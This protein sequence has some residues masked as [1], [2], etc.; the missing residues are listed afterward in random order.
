MH[1][2]FNLSLPTG[3]MKIFFFHPPLFASKLYRAPQSMQLATPNSCKFSSPKWKN[4][5][6]RSSLFKRPRNS[7]RSLMKSAF[8]GGYTFLFSD[9]DKSYLPWLKYFQGEMQHGYQKKNIIQHKKLENIKLNINRP[10]II[11]S[12]TQVNISGLAKFVE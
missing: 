4:P 5:S 7:S 9:A 6:L 12:R 11:Y 3:T 8:H 10:S 2:Y 1:I